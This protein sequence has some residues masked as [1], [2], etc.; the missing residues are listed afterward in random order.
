MVCLSKIL[1]ALTGHRGA[2]EHTMWK[3]ITAD[4]A[5]LT[6]G[7][8]R[9]TAPVIQESIPAKLWPGLS[10]PGL[11]S[12]HS[13]SPQ[14]RNPDP[15][16]ECCTVSLVVR[17]VQTCNLMLPLRASLKAKTR[18]RHRC[19]VIWAQPYTDRHVHESAVVGLCPKNLD[20]RGA[21]EAAPP[22]CTFGVSGCRTSVS[23]VSWTCAS[24]RC[25]SR[26][27][28]RSKSRGVGK[29]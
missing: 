5:V 23:H 6:F 14:R 22:G 27:G 15:Q 21:V 2:T 4:V 10:I 17:N 12:Q 20:L 19:H 29:V 9:P 18:R 7:C 16:I 25:P 1:H 8:E 28:V 11:K 13:V 24:R 26:R 3:W